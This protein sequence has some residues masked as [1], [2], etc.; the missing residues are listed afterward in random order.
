MYQYE[1]HI[2][3]SFIHGES[4]CWGLKGTGHPAVVVLGDMETPLGSSF[5]YLRHAAA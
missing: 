4:F 1:I 2:L 3:D 5:G